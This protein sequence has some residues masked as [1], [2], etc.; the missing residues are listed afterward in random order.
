MHP[1]QYVLERRVD[2]TREFAYVTLLRKR[3][4]SKTTSTPG[5]TIDGAG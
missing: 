2:A 5:V 4:D 3:H 1:T